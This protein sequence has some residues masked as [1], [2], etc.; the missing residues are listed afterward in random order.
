[1]K[2][3]GNGY[4]MS[5]E[6]IEQIIEL[7]T[8]TEMTVS[9]IAECMFC[10]RGAVLSINRRFQVRRLITGRVAPFVFDEQIEK[11]PA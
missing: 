2:F 8:S 4:I 6:S 11:K 9:E 5:Q 10:S 1:M 3:S 7:L